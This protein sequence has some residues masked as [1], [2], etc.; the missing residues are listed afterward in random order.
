M[1]EKDK[2]HAA[3]KVLQTEGFYRQVLE[4][5]GFDWM[6]ISVSDQLNPNPLCCTLIVWLNEPLWMSDRLESEFMKLHI[7]CLCVEWTIWKSDQLESESMK[8]HIASVWMNH[9]EYMNASIR[10]IRIRR[11][12]IAYW[13][14]ECWMNHEYQI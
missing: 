1:Y 6:N 13:M 5:E 3:D 10:Q 7:E 11:H 9:Y 8:L 14:S 4:T 12:G 2:A